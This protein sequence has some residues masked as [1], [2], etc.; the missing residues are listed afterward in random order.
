V[1][2]LVSAAAGVLT[3]AVVVL[4][5]A[6]YF[7]VS[8]RYM[9]GLLEA[10]AE[11]NSGI[12]NRVVS[13]NPELWRYE[14]V[15]LSEHL[16]RRPRQGD[17]ERRVVLDAQGAIVAESVDPLPRPWLTRSVPLLDAGTPVGTIEI[18][19][20]LMPLLLHSGLLALALLAMGL[21]SFRTIRSVPLR[22]IRRS[23]EA[24]RRE[25]DT[26]QK[27]LD[28]AGVAFVIVDETG[29]VTLVNR[30]GC[31]ILGRSEE[32]V[33]GREWI[34]TFVD[35]AD[36]AGVAAETSATERPHHLVE[37]EYAVL[38][39]SG[40]RRV[41]SW[42]VAPIFD[43]ESR[44][45]GLLSSGVDVTAQRQLEAQ[46]HNAQ[47]LEAIGR[48]AGGV[49]HDFNNLLSVI[50]GYAILL[51][52]RIGEN[53]P[54]RRYAEQ[55]LASIERAA[56]LTTSLLTFGRRQVL[57]PEPMDLADFVR[58]CEEPL[59]RLLRE[60]VELRTVLA[61][62]PLPLRADRLQVERVL[63]NLVTNAQ[64]ALPGGGRIVITASRAML[65]AGD[66]RR[67]G[68][69]TPGPYAQL[70]ITDN[71]TGIPAEVQAHLFE[72]FFTTK[73]L[74]RGTGLGLS[75][76]Y[77][78]VKQHHGVIQVASA[79]GAG[80]TFTLLL[81]LVDASPAA[82][83]Q[84]DADGATPPG[85]TETVLVADDD[86]SLREKLRHILEGA[87]YAVVEAV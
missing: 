32:E 54:L 16:S 21:L 75:I 58:R 27:Y 29:R 1:R 71:G 43:A 40:E 69:E 53:D 14:Q 34:A 25:R 44:R 41:I 50:K 73:E 19:R 80:T 28:V 59:R 65:D 62:E 33:L 26:A 77:A 37:M 82:K 22:A 4:P 78:I 51:R 7:L 46:L 23:E 12:V 84:P 31:E 55:I 5:P 86:A 17:A 10:E 15:R 35:P 67:A 11:I 61:P 42:Y 13:A 63:M 85:G 74:G 66:A 38:R 60:D 30:K 70:S 57:H 18:S 72:P 6:I 79:P 52:K 24:L 8:Y 49:A 45:T 48:L 2:K 81:P 39:S 68:L 3:A 20:S 64:D 47:K 56:A 36:R 76:A 87:G 83:A 9:T